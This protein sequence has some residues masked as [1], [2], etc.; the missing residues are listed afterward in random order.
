LTAGN[1]PPSSHTFS[2][3]HTYKPLE[4]ERE[5]GNGAPDFFSNRS[6][7]N[8]RFQTTTA[9]RLTHAH[10][11]GIKDLSKLISDEAPG[12]VKETKYESY[13]GA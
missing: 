12:A 13:F 7:L 9:F 1:A 3:L 8:S 10:I 6:N 2:L 5:D 11:M 4:R